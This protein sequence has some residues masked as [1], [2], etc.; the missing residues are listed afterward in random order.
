[1]ST[2]PA[3]RVIALHEYRKGGDT[4]FGVVGFMADTNINRQS[5]ADYWKSKR[6][7]KTDRNSKPV[8]TPTQRKRLIARCFAGLV[9]PKVRN[10]KNICWIWALWT[11]FEE[12]GDHPKLSLIGYTWSVHRL[13]FEH[14]RGPL[15]PREPLTQTCSDKACVNPYHFEKKQPKRKSKGLPVDDLDFLFIVAEKQK[16]R[17]VK[18]STYSEIDQAIEWLN[19]SDIQLTAKRTARDEIT[20]FPNIH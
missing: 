14:L 19:A 10:A 11:Q 20:L 3:E 17:G 13:L 15:Q 9:N 12:Q 6:G 4:T 1:M 16:E 8:L 18:P 7:E 5:K 2:L